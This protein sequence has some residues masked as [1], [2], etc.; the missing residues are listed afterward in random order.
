MSETFV[1]HLHRFLGLTVQVFTTS[2]GVSGSGF[3]G[4]L[5]NIHADFITL[6]ASVAAP[7]A[8]APVPAVNVAPIPPGASIDIPIDRIA[9]FVHNTT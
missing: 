1:E 7:P 3:L 5:S 4:V 8:G 9:A 6:V 2:G